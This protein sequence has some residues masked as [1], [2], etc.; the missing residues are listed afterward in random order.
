MELKAI[1][2]AQISQEEKGKYRMVLLLCGIQRNQTEGQEKSQNYRVD[3]NT[4]HSAKG[5][6]GGG[7]QHRDEHRDGSD[8]GGGTMV[9]QCQT[10]N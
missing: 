4:V 2:P 1:M 3:H 10:N 5:M 7:H 6:G 9:I 8:S